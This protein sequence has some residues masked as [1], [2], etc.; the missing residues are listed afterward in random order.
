MTFSTNA[1]SCLLFYEIDNLEVQT[2]SS[3]MGILIEKGA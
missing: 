1:V 3:S 2:I